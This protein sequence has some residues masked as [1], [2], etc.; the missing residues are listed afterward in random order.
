MLMRFV[1]LA[2][3]LLSL[4]LGACATPTEM[5]FSPE[6]KGPVTVSKPVY[7]M[8]LT[9]KNVYHTSHQPKVTV[10]YVERPEAKEKA[11]RL[12]FKTDKASRE[13]TD[14]SE[15]STYYIRMELD[16]SQWVLRGFSAISSSFPIH[17]FFFGPL[18]Y[19]LPVREPGVY[20]LGHVDATVRERE[21]EE[22]RAGPLLPLVD[23]AIA[24]ASGG[25]FD[26]T[27]SDRWATDESV[28]RTRF[29]AMAELPVTVAVLPP[30]D[31]AK[32]QKFW[33]SH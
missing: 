4:L 10:M 5:A 1:P 8:T 12:N 11:E 17:G 3:A 31:R 6:A 33:E 28:F 32:A 2:A 7:L 16:V 14:T 29:P 15:G 23:Q 20:Y 18:H 9:V 13:E 27:V 22:F 24:G 21:G 30:F 19:D 26:I 25:S